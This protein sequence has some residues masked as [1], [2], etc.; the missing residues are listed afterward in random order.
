MVTTII[1]LFSFLLCLLQI[2]VIFF[3]LE[4]RFSIKKLGNTIQEALLSQHLILT[5]HI[6]VP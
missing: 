3:S 6:S 1:H 2:Y 5:E 4:N